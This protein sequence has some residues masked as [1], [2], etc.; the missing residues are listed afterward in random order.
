MNEI[1]RPREAE[2]ANSTTPIVTSDA[3]SKGRRRGGDQCGGCRAGLSRIDSLALGF[4][5]TCRL[6]AEA[7]PA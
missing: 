3:T 6:T 4:C 2:A 1:S 5:L 7:V